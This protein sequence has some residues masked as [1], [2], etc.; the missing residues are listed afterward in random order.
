MP[1]TRSTRATSSVSPACACAR[2]RKARR[3]PEHRSGEVQHHLGERLEVCPPRAGTTTAPSLRRRRRVLGQRRRRHRQDRA[4]RL[5]RQRPVP[6]RLAT[7]RLAS[8]QHVQVHLALDA[9]PSSRTSARPR[10]AAPRAAP[11]R[12]AAAAGASAGSGA[13]KSRMSCRRTS[14]DAFLPDASSNSSVTFAWTT[15]PDGSGDGDCTKRRPVALP[16]EGGTT[17]GCDR[18]LAHRRRGQVRLG[19]AGKDLAGRGHR[20]RRVGVGHHEREGPRPVR[21]RRVSVDAVGGEARLHHASTRGGRVSKRARW[22]VPSGRPF[23]VTSRPGPTGVSARTSKAASGD[24]P[25]GSSPGRPCAESGVRRNCV[26]CDTASVRH[27]QHQLE[28]DRPRQLDLRQD[29]PVRSHRH[30]LARAA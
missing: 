9:A 23:T 13:R 12:P 15:V 19:H 18:R 14:S 28:R 10:P 26:G 27:V 20:R 11:S 25:S 1:R 17:D 30:R 6:A 24:Q 22:S 21:G 4:A 16:P 7:H 3:R 2:N 29:E 5:Q 8:R